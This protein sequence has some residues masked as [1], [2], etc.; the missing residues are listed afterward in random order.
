MP[1]AMARCLETS[2]EV[3]RTS[4]QLGLSPICASQHAAYGGSIETDHQALCLMPIAGVSNFALPEC[5]SDRPEPMSQYVDPDHHDR[6]A[7]W[8][9]DLQAVHADAAT[10]AEETEYSNVVERLV[11]HRCAT[12][13]PF[14]HPA[15]SLLGPAPSIATVICACHSSPMAGHSGI[16]RT[17]HRLA[18]RFWWPTLNRETHHA[19]SG[20]AHCR[21]ANIASHEAQL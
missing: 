8:M 13:P 16:Y 17:H 12:K 19:V 10:R 20:C 15:Y 6:D 18:A 1:L 4:V 14:G 7:L 9:D 11:K 5:S 3:P 21:L 2:A